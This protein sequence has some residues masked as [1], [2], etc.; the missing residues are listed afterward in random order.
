MSK[1]LRTNLAYL[2]FI[3]GRLTQKAVS[4]GTGI[5]Q[6]TLSAL[7]TGA[8]KGIE[9]NTLIKLCTFFRCTPSDLL[10]IEED[11]DD[12]PVSE[13]S[14]QTAR[15]LVA[16]G[17]QAAMGASAADPEQVWAEFDNVRARLQKAAKTVPNTQI[18]ERKEERSTKGA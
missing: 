15:Q 3:N 1:Q 12:M 7:E 10:V 11:V 9:F 2:R 14:R 8:S 4:E 16:S 5:G 6:K 13:Q 18:N 17:L